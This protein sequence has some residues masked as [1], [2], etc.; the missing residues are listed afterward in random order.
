VEV[1]KEE[2]KVIKGISSSQYYLPN[3]LEI[4]FNNILTR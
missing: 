2:D 4:K 1:R 3:N